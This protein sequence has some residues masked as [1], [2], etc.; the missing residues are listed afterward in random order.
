MWSPT[1]SHRR[2]LRYG[3]DDETTPRHGRPLRLLL[4][5]WLAR[6]HDPGV[7]RPLDGDLGRDL[8]WVLALGLVVTGIASDDRSHP[9]HDEE[10]VVAIVAG[11]S[12]IGSRHAAE[13]L[14][15]A[16]VEPHRSPCGTGGGSRTRCPLP[17]HSVLVARAGR[18]RG[19]ALR[20]L[21]SNLTGLESGSSGATS[22]L[23]TTMWGM[24]RATS[25]LAISSF[26][27]P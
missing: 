26:F 4:S 23:I 22:I 15:M 5:V 24:I 6:V 14:A 17:P 7:G 8:P 2:R 25:S 9:S 10:A 13:H 21:Y 27:K 1:P 18:G 19:G 20:L 11:I 3:S 12:V 16:P